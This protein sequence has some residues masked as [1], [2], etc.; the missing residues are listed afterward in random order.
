[1]TYGP[2][3]RPI[4]ERFWEKV[5]ATGDCWEWTSTRRNNY[6][7]FWI[8]GTRFVQAHRQA[9]EFLVG[10]IP[11]GLHLDHLCRNVGCV[12]P[13]HLEPVT[14]QENF[15]RGYR[16]GTNPPSLCHGTALDPTVSKRYL[17]TDRCPECD[18]LA[19]RGMRAWRYQGKPGVE[20]CLDSND[21]EFVRLIR[22]P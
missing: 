20:P 13:D 7:R 1:M 15:R 18:A 21:P 8:E 14:P 19:R 6:G 9:W 17:G 4:Q 12:N 11:E 22:M 5:D 10:L 3:P 2:D 16:W